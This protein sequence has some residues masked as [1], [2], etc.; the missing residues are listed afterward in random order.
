M[1]API[2]SAPRR[3]AVTVPSAGQVT[4]LQ[5]VRE[6]PAISLLLTTTP[7]ATLAHADAL[8]LEGL[9]GQAVERVRA[10]LRPE[11]AAPAVRRLRDLVDEARRGPTTAALAVY[12]SAS[13][14]ALVR[15]P[16]PVRDRAVVDPT[17]ATR[18]LVRALHRTPRHLV[19]ALRSEE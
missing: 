5:S 16:L 11:A 17:F 1:S 13:T 9:A 12:A 4:A 3:P 7:G 14:G 2:R 10:E 15:L 6:Y 18:D 19:L 8:R